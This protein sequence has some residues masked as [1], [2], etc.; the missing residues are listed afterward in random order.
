[1]RYLTIAAAAVMVLGIAP[2]LRADAASHEAA[3]RQL[4]NTMQMGELMDKT[5]NQ[6]LDVQIQQNPQL[7]PYRNVMLAFFRKYLSWEAIEPEMIKLYTDT[8]SE[9]ELKAIVQF[10]QTPAGQKAIKTLPE[11]MSRG[12]EIGQRKVQENIGELQQMV[13]AEEA[14]LH[15]GSPATRPAQP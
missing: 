7:A 15:G 14:R 12:A 11:L 4:I 10:Y 1:M 6:M 5:I 8:F 13:A 3:A 2:T 9:D